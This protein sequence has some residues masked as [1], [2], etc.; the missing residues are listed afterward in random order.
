MIN[1]S[2]TTSNFTSKQLDDDVEV[3]RLESSYDSEFKGGPSSEA[4]T[5]QL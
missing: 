4:N 3:S 1:Q 2:L 5:T